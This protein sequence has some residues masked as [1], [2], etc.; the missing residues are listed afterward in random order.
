[1]EGGGKEEAIYFPLWERALQRT[2]RVGATEGDCSWL[3]VQRPWGWSQE[4]GHLGCLS[5]GSAVPGA[6]VAL[7]LGAQQRLE[8]CGPQP[9]VVVPWL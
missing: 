6:T 2:A 4:H 5:R 7:C 8:A 3:G 9:S 1:M